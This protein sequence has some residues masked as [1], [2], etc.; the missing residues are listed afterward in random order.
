MTHALPF[1]MIGCSIIILVKIFG[2]ISF[3]LCSIEKRVA[4]LTYWED[5]RAHRESSNEL[6]ALVNEN[7][8]AHKSEEHH[9]I[10]PQPDV[11]PDVQPENNRSENACSKVDEIDILN[12]F[13]CHEYEP[14]ET[15]KE[16]ARSR[17]FELRVLLIDG[18]AP[19]GV[20]DDNSHISPNVIGVSVCTTIG[21]FGETCMF[22]DEFI[23]VGG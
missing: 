1:A 7:K 2:K 8:R 16:I 4:S 11:Q 3:R 18:R 12:G 20:H 23:N 13:R 9:V 19:Q 5:E 14:F 15:V 22:V 10:D 21:E 17:G 6:S